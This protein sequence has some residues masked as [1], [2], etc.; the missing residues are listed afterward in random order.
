MR[1][2]QN[3][4]R[5]H[6]QKGHALVRKRR[7]FNHGF[8]QDAILFACSCG[9]TGWLPVDDLLFLSPDLVPTEE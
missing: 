6:D 3:R 5:E 4:L 2:T 1:R 7:A 8:H 9:W